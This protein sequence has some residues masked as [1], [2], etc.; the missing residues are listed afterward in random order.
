MCVLSVAL[1]DD[2]GVLQDV[3]ESLRIQRGSGFLINA[4]SN[5]GLVK[6]LCY[7]RTENI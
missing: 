7:R 6:V 3:L 4:Y 1:F 5:D 2:S